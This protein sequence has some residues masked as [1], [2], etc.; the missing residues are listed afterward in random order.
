VVRAN[1]EGEQEETEPLSLVQ[2]AVLA[3][4][5]DL[6]AERLGPGGALAVAPFAPAIEVLA[7]RVRSEFRAASER[8][9]AEVLVAAAAA[10]GST[11]EEFADMVG[12]SD[13]TVLLT[14]RAMAGAAGTAWP[15]KVYALGRALADG[16]I[17]DD[18]QVNV[19][20]L[21]I[22]AMSDMERLHVNL[23]D[24]F[25]S[26]RPGRS[27]TDLWEYVPH[28]KLPDD[29]DEIVWSG[30]ERGWT[31]REIESVRPALAPVITSLIGTLERHGLIDQYDHTFQAIESYA[32][33][34][35]KEAG[36]DA[37]HM[38]PRESRVAVS[39]GRPGGVYPIGIAPPDKSWSSTP[40]GKQVL[41]YYHMAATEFGADPGS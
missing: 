7:S 3:T 38:E 20:D 34:D 31:L 33:L 2:R 41:E 9:Q 25:V 19:A 37:K 30:G 18:D 36:R 17:A 10:A 26:W 27:Q 11:S 23:L 35:E 24:L 39:T 8:R 22:P 29:E 15:T 1:D 12:K 14:A 16:L 28:R 40:L 13:H 21:V 6:L 32:K 5:I 4:A